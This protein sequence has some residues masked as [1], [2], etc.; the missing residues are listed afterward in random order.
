MIGVEKQHDIGE[1]KLPQAENFRKI[2]PEGPITSAEA[3]SFWKGEFSGKTVEN[4]KVY[5]DDNNT[6]LCKTKRGI[7]EMF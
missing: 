1:V 4:P 2:K 3:G 5:V 7:Y 6:I